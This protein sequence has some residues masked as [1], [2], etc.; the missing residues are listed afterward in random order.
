MGLGPLLEGAG[1]PEQAAP[2]V[3]ERVPDP[4]GSVT[5]RAATGGR[6]VR[7]TTVY[8]VTGATGALGRLAVEALLE[9]V[10]AEQVGA[11]GRRVETLDDFAV[12]GVDVRRGDYDTAVRQVVAPV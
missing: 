2:E 5:T 7:E 8:V 4:R 9:R 10:P 12:Y 6:V 11:T 1:E 3:G